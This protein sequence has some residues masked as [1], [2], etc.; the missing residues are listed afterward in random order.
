[1]ANNYGLFFTNKNTGAVIR[2]PVNPESLPASRD[3]ANDDLNVLGIGPIMVPRIPELKKIE[4]ASYFPGRPDLLTLTAGSFQPPSFYISFFEGAMLNKEI[5]TYT[6]VRYYEDGEQYLLDDNGY[7]VLVVGFEYEERGAETGDFY[8]TLNLSEYRDYTP[9]KMQLQT[10]KDKA[11][12]AAIATT[13]PTR[14]IPKNQLVVGSTVIANGKY[15][16][17]ATGAEPHGNGN[18]RRCKVSRIEASKPY[19]VHI[20]TEAGGA[21]GWIKKDALQVVDDE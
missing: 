20:A 5:L 17:S 16:Y 18:G 4:I 19:P 11:T 12:G 3:T 21:L 1:M 13:E 6:P 2:L 15:Y 8:Y 14:S 10:N 7:D 9:T